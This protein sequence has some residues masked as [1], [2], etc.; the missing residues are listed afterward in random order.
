MDGKNWAITEQKCDACGKP[1]R[2]MKT[3]DRGWVSMCIESG[4]P[5]NG[6]PMAILTDIFFEAEAEV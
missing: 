3:S 4:C 5:L 1:T 2:V 6:E